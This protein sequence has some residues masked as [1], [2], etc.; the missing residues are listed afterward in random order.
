VCDDP[1]TVAQGAHAI[2]LM[3]PWP[4][5]KQLDLARL[6]SSMHSPAFLDTANMLDPDQVTQAG[7]LYQGI[8][9]G[10]APRAGGDLTVRVGIV[11]AGLQARRRGP[12]LMQFP[13]TELIVVS[14]A[15]PESARH[16][17]ARLGCEAADG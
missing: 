8:G 12:V 6:R 5:F 1:Y 13:G 15:H 9:R 14:A 4:E 10:S 3:T 2:V 11:G 17:A 16:L 7:F